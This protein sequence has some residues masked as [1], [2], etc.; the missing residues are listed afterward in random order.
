[1]LGDSPDADDAFQATFLVLVRKA[2][3]LDRPEQVAGW[4]HRVALRVARKARAE[5]ARR[6]AREEVIVDVA[7]PTPHEDTRALRQELDEELDRLPE[8]YRLPIVLCELE[9]RTLDE[10][11]QLL[12]WPKGTVAGRLSRGRDLLRRRLSRR[13]GLI[14]PLFLV[15]GLPPPEPLVG[16]ALQAATAADSG[17]RAALLA[18]LALCRSRSLV[19]LVL[20]LLLAGGALRG[21]RDRRVERPRT[22]RMPRAAHFPVLCARLHGASR[23]SLIVIR[24]FVDR[25]FDPDHVRFGRPSSV[26]SCLPRRFDHAS[27]SVTHPASPATTGTARG[28][29]ESE[30]RLPRDRS[31]CRP[32]G[33]CTDHRSDL[34]KRLGNLPEPGRRSVLGVRQRDRPERGLYRRRERQPT[35]RTIRGRDTG[36]VTHGAGLQRT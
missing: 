11:A 15:G 24:P 4:L 2:K 36:R 9:G 13:R 34:R 31:H 18:D 21:R 3:S 35:D 19:G 22:P 26:S 25:S 29:I 28:P 10:A 30:H 32:A 12:G 8:K 5:R 16:S 1:M 33:C 20:L 14:L 17:S 7:M 6:H 23:P 27:L